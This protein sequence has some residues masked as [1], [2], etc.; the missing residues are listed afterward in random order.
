MFFFFQYF[1][2]KYE[3]MKFLGWIFDKRP[4]EKLLGGIVVEV[5]ESVRGYWAYLFEGRS[6]NW[7]SQW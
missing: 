2:V 7:M 1:V 6:S 4:R 3:L 5:D